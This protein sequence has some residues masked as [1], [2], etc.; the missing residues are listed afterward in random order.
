M[1]SLLSESN[2]WRHTAQE[3]FSQKIPKIRSW[4]ERSVTYD[5]CEKVFAVFCVN[6]FRP[7]QPPNAP[8]PKRADSYVSVSLDKRRT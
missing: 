7:I 5:L 4:I 2:R 1:W 3:K 6:L 8:V